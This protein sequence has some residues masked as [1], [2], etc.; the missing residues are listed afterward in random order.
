MAVVNQVP[1]D[2]TCCEIGA[3]ALTLTGTQSISYGNS[4]ETEKIGGSTNE[5]IDATPGMGHADDAEWSM[6]ESDYRALI[7]FLGPGYMTLQKRFPLS[8]S[9]AFTG[10][11]L[12]TD[13][14]QK[15]RIIKDAHDLQKG[16]A[17]LTVSVTLQVMKCLP[18]GINPHS[19]TA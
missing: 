3:G 14:L 10:Q 1:Y 19:T 9:Y 7:A 8:V 18:G 5:D 6:L 17:G 4:V 15:C 2:F 12:I 13:E 16:A 11:A